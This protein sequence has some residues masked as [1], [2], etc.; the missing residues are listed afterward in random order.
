MSIVTSVL[1]RKYCVQRF[2]YNSVERDFSPHFFWEYLENIGCYV[3]FVPTYKYGR[4]GI[5]IYKQR[6]SRCL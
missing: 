3:N 2:L 4:T 5:C 6:R 1:K